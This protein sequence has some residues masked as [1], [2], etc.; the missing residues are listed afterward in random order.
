MAVSV[1]MAVVPYVC[2][3]IVV[4]VVVWWLIFASRGVE[5]S[6]IKWSVITH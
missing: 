1:V 5:H 3:T 6:Y 4:T 2:G